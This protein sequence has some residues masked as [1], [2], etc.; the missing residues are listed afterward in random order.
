VG[1]YAGAS[2]AFT[3]AFFPTAGAP[4]LAQVWSALL[5][6]THFAKLQA[7]QWLMDA[8]ASVSLV[9]VLTLIAFIAAFSV[10]GFLLYA[11][12]AR[13]PDDWGRR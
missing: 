1:L 10:P 6:F 2:F 12:S 8:P 7:E 11:R 4:L 5:P 3:G 9:H 13:Q